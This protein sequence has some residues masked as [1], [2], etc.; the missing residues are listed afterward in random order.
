[1]SNLHDCAIFALPSDRN[2]AIDFT[3]SF[4]C[5]FLYTILEGMFSQ[6]SVEIINC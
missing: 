2:I 3:V 1:M 5:I 4:F 6:R